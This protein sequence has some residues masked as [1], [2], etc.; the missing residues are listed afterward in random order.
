MANLVT[1][2][3]SLTQGFQSGG[4]SKNDLSYPALIA[5][6]MGLVIG[7]N[8]KVPELRGPG[9]TIGATTGLGGLL[10]NIEDIARIWDTTPNILGLLDPIRDGEIGLYLA[11]V[12]NY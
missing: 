9:V 11:Q 1:I 8:F 10:A 6:A 2:G 12:K 5:N 4:I 3:D 7:G